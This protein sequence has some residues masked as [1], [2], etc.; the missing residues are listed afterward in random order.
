MLGVPQTIEAQA[1][2]LP[3][4]TIMQV[5]LYSGRVATVL[6][7]LQ[8]VGAQ[9]T[10]LLVSLAVYGGTWALAARAMALRA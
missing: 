8:I 5:H 2:C 9:A 6:G 10:S 4:C 7:V 3:L 1:M